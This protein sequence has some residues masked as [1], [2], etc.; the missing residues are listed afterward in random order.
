M[1]VIN[2]S[3]IN[4]A[5]LIFQGG[6]PGRG[7]SLLDRGGNQTHDLWFATPSYEVK[8]VQNILIIHDCLDENTID[9]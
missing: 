7:K 6:T 2:K 9:M 8:S 1:L 3:V 4:R 5:G